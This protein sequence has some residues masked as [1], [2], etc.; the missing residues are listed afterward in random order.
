MPPLTIK[1]LWLALAS[2]LVSALPLPI[3]LNLVLWPIPVGSDGSMGVLGQ[4]MPWQL[5]THLLVNS[6]VSAMLFIGLTLYFFGAMLESTWRPRRYGLFLLACAAGSTLLQFLASTVAFA[7]GVGPYAPTAGADGVMYGILFAC[8]Y[9]W[10]DERVMLI[11]P[12]IPMKMQ[13]LVIVLCA[14]N[15][16]FGLWH[17]G[18]L[19]QFGFLGGLAGAWLHIQYWRGQPPFS[20]KKPPPPKLRIVS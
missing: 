15:F 9:L 8:A 1:L 11:I 4:F 18:L 2:L 7:S 10:P 6:G 3:L 13:T 5:A 20:R 17:G 12:P 16:S 14:L 19:S